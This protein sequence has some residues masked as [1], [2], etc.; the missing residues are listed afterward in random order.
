MPKM[1]WLPEYPAPTMRGLSWFGVVSIASEPFLATV[2]QAHPAA[3]RQVSLLR[4]FGY[5]FQKN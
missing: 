4:Y 1:G 2:S 3:H 5:A